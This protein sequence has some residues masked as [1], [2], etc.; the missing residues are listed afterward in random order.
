MENISQTVALGANCSCSS[1]EV[2]LQGCCQEQET[3]GNFTSPPVLPIDR[4]QEEPSW[5]RK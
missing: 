1:E 3:A 4:A 5:Q 2:L